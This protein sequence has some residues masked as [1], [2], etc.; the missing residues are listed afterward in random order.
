ALASDPSGTALGSTLS[1]QARVE[2]WSRALLMLQ[3]FPFTGIGLNTFPV[4]LQALYPPFLTG[5]DETIPHAHNL[6]LQTGVDL[7]IP[8]LLA[9]LWI[10]GLVWRCWLRAWRTDERARAAQ[11]VGLLSAAT[12]WISRPAALAGVLA[13]ITGHLVFGLTDAVTLGAK[14]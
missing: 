11:G 13:G 12:D 1:L 2:I 10:L 9:F 14:P 7:G 6:F 5:P 4:V 3:D 8:G